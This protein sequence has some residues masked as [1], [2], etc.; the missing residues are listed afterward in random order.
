[1]AL[2]R[3]DAPDAPTPPRAGGSPAEQHNL[4]GASTVVEGALRSSGNLNISGT[5]VGNVAVEGRTILMPGGTVEGE[6]VST[7][8]EIAGRITGTLTVRERLV[9][10]G[11][12]V[13]E[14]DIRAG[15]LVIED[16]AVFN[17]RC[18]MGRAAETT[19]SETTPSEPA[20]R[21]L[22]ADVDG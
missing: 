3:S 22:P 2:F 5:V 16:G 11:T 1:M 18:E 13:V 4:I 15:S 9:L 6:V 19:P 10:K 8:A 21:R 17:G 7:Q 14:G 20:V 12:A